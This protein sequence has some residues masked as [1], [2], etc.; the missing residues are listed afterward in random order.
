MKKLLL[1]VLSAVMLV[2]VLAGLVLLLWQ[3]GK[4]LLGLT[5]DPR[6]RIAEL[7]AQAAH[8]EAEQAYSEYMEIRAEADR[9][10]QQVD[11]AEEAGENM[12]RHSVAQ[13]YT[14]HARAHTALALSLPSLTGLALLAVAVMG[15]VAWR[16]EKGRSYD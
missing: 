9:L 5:E 1:K 3:I 8:S 6:V 16:Q 11:L 2:V 14:L 4:Q 7:D 10:R 13:G 12:I 15:I